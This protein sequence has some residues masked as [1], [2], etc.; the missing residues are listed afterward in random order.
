MNSFGKASTL[1]PGVDAG[2][3]EAKLLMSDLDA[4]I[5]PK[6]T[7]A[8][9]ASSVVKAAFSKTDNHIHRWKPPAE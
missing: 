1:D 6:R 4:T 9:G 5:R 8:R 7:C 3:D 2:M